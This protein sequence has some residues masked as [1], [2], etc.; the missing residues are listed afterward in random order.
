MPLGIEP[1]TCT[2]EKRAVQKALY[3]PPQVTTY[4]IQNP[5]RDD[6]RKV[7]GY[8]R[9]KVRA[10][11]LSFHNMCL[12]LIMPDKQ[13]EMNLFHHAEADHYVSSHII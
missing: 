1:I 11:N 2:T 5:D 12:K 3:S 10:M 7:N 6:Y 8:I 9:S 4:F 13:A